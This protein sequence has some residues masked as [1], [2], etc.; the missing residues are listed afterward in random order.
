MNS[1]PEP[2]FPNAG[3]HYMPDPIIAWSFHSTS[4]KKTVFHDTRGKVTKTIFLA[5]FIEE[6]QAFKPKIRKTKE[7]KKAN[8]N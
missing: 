2:S 4:S 8:G 1:A 7:Q 3:C 6:A 5:V